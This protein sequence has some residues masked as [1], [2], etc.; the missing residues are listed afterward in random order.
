MR[1]T[2]RS[3]DHLRRLVLGAF[4]AAVLGAIAAAGSGVYAEQTM[5][6]NDP[7][8]AGSNAWCRD[9]GCDA[10]SDTLCVEE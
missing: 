7:C 10:C 1:D 5:C 6:L 2:R 4:L 8:K 9:L 3:G